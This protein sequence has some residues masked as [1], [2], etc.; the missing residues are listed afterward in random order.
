MEWYKTAER[1]KTAALKAS[2][3][4][5]LVFLWELLPRLGFVDPQ[6]FPPLSA[7]LEAT[8]QLAV[9]GVLLTSVM[10]SLWRA[11]T[12]LFAALVL[13]L[14][15]GLFFGRAPFF[16]EESC[17][18]LF[19]FFS[20][21][22]P[23]SLLPVFIL[24]FGIGETAKIAIV[25]WVCIWPVFFNTAAGARNIDRILVKTARSCGPGPL[26][27]FFTVILPAS[28]ASIFTGLRL[29]LEMSFFML[30]AAEMVGASFGI[31]WLL[32]NSGMNA[33]FGRMYAA[34]LMA[35]SLSCS[36]TGFLKY[37]EGRSFFWREGLKET[38]RGARRKALTKTDIGFAAALGF[39]IFAA[40]I[41]Q[42]H[43]AKTEQARF[44]HTGH[45]EHMPVTRGASME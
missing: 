37:I 23:F 19:R 13:G 21:F 6:F 18:P 25:A 5:L 35:V 30:L 16:V 8:G 26:R 27:F 3:I 40:G 45:S 34:I 38:I 36:L 29:G 32:H 4:L 17:Y 15:L 44:N 7:V 9:S 12:S 31:G 41:W 39:F 1:L 42:L 33:Q 2:G 10:V 22:N 28:S 24:F 14:P 20:Q 11:L 43:V